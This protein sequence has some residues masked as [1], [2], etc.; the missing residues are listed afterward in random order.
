MTLK[1][2]L[3]GIIFLIAVIFAMSGSWDDKNLRKVA[4]DCSLS[5]ISPDY[6]IQVKEACRKM[7][8]ERSTR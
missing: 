3:V 2:I 4:Y 5:E 1:E 7:R 6:P 8:A